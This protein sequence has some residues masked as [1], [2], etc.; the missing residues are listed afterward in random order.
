MKVARLL[1]VV[2]I[3]GVI[4]TACGGSNN[5]TTTTAT[6]PSDL[7]ISSFDASF[8]YMSKLTDLTKAGKGLVRDLPGHQHLLRQLRHRPGRQAHRQRLHG[9]CHGVEGQQPEGL[10]ARWR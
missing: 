1:P 10:H 5:P 8:S 3:V 4:I 7:S 9:L 6:V 2:A